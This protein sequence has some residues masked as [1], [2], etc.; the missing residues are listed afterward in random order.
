MEF[1]NLWNALGNRVILIFSRQKPC[2]RIIKNN[3][4]SRAIDV[5]SYLYF[6]TLLRIWLF[7]PYLAVCKFM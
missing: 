4:T 1:Y 7:L 6:I 3:I 2:T 5:I